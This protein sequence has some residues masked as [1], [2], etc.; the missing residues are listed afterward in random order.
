VLGIEEGFVRVHFDGQKASEDEWIPV[1]EK[2]LFD[3]SMVHCQ[4][5]DLGTLTE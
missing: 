2:R 4:P 1:K 5:K 3:Q